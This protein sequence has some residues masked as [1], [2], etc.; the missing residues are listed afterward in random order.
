[1]ADE[2]EGRNKET[3]GGEKGGRGGG[4]EAFCLIVSKD[5]CVKWYQF[6][7]LVNSIRQEREVQL[8]SNVV[9]LSA[10]GLKGKGSW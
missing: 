9:T 1:M 6:R 8:L 3:G 4:D 10:A 5:Q 7:L 2:S